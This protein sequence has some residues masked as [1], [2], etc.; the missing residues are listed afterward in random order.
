[1]SEAAPNPTLHIIKL[2]VGTDSIDDLARWQEFRLIAK[3]P[4]ADDGG[5]A[6]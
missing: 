1:M 2:S 6:T 4:L 3:V 5:A